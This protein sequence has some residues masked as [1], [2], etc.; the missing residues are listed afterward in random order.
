MKKGVLVKLPKDELSHS[1]QT[2]EWWYFNGFLNSIK[3]KKKYAFMTCLF[4]GNLNKLNLS[5]LK[6]PV[7]QV[8]FSHT[9]LYDLNSKKVKR[10]LIP[11]ALVSKESFKKPELFINYSSPLKIN[12]QKYEIERISK[13][14]QL[15][16]PFFNLNLEQK[17]PAIYED[18]TGLIKLKKKS[19]YYYSYPNLSAEGYV[20]KDKVSGK[21]WHDKQWSKQ[22]YMKDKWLWFSVQLPNNTEIICLNYGDEKKIIDVSLPNGT[23]KQFN[24]EFKPIKKPWKS[25][26]SKRSYELEWEIKAGPYKITTKPFIN[27][28]EMNFGSIHYWE[29]PIQVKVN[30]ISGVGFMEYLLQPL[31]EGIIETLNDYKD[32]IED[33]LR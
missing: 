9:L 16:T 32:L 13:S 2:I 14:L 18:E 4:K 24:A 17:K 12:S 31:D 26:R 11:F 29:G 30:G 8:Y 27:D 23:Q 1:G 15:K 10:E 6:I 22:G 19:S 20:G 25:K 5:F 33:S 28:C 7:N 3:S 21:V